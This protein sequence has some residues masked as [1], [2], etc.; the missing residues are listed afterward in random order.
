MAVRGLDTDNLPIQQ[1]GISILM[2]NK[3]TSISYY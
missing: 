2:P 3:Y 1:E